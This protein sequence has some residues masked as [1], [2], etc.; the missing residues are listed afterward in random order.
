MY[1]SVLRMYMMQRIGETWTA[2]FCALCKEFYRPDEDGYPTPESCKE[3]PYFLKFGSC[4]GGQ[5]NN[6]RYIRK[7][8]DWVELRTALEAVRDQLLSLIEGE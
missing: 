8:T 6:W 5:K 3:C 7:A 1:K 2:E 4:E